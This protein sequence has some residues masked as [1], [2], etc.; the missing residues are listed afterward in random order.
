MHDGNWTKLTGIGIVA[1]V[2]LSLFLISSKRKFSIDLNKKITFIF[3]GL[4]FSSLTSFSII[5]KFKPIYVYG[6][7][8]LLFLC[9]RIISSNLIDVDKFFIKIAIG[10]SLL[11]LVIIILGLD[12]PFLGDRTFS[13]YRFS[14]FFDNPNAMGIFSA[15]L[16]HIIL[17]NS[18]C[19]L[20]KN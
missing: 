20:S 18:I 19:S 13:F 8:I 10:A 11:G 3:L 15:G 5:G 12:Q 4:I 1:F 2:T 7:L 6:S 16:I 17:G 9:V 14:G